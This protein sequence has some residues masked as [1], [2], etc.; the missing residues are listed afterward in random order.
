VELTVQISNPKAPLYCFLLVGRAATGAPVKV[1]PGVTAA[2]AHLTEPRG[3]DVASALAIVLTV[4]ANVPAG[5]LADW[6]YGRLCTYRGRPVAPEAI[7]IERQ[8]IE[9]SKAEM[10]RVLQEAIS[11]QSDGR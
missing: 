11:A 4:A 6:L 1:M 9:F 7:T 8:T 5:L 2:R 10:A 3:D